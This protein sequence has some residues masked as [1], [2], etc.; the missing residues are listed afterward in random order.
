MY[1]RSADSSTSQLQC[2][3]VGA[4]FS[5]SHNT[6]AYVVAER[7]AVLMY[8]KFCSHCGGAEGR[9]TEVKQARLDLDLVDVAC[10]AA[11]WL[12]GWLA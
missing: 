3:A 7:L 12:A 11:G 8:C 5:K 2:C 4:F 10:R 6:T 1:N 9:K